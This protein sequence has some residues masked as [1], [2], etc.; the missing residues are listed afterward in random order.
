M[1]LQK[2]QTSARVQAQTACEW[3][4]KLKRE[5]KQMKPTTRKGVQTFLNT[6]Y[7]LCRFANYC[8]IPFMLVS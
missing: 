7:Q 3:N 1:E 8:N 2:G 4:K 5:G 6:M